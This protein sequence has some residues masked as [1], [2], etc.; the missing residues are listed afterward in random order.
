MKLFLYVVAHEG[1][2]QLDV[3]MNLDPRATFNSSGSWVRNAIYQLEKMGFIYPGTDPER[4]ELED[5][6]GKHSKSVVRLYVNW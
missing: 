2:Y 1:M 5:Q 4:D 3:I 6:K